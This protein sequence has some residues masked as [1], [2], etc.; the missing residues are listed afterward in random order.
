MRIAFFGTPDPAA[1]LLEAVVGSGFEVGPVVTAEDKPK[2]RGLHL[3]PSPVKRLALEMGLRVLTPKTLKD[4]NFLKA[5]GEF[6]AE[7]ALVCAYGHLIPKALLSSLP[8]GF[9]NVHY[10]LLPRYRGASCVPFTILF[11]ERV[12]GVSFIVLDEGLD[13]GPILAQFPLAIEKEDTAGSLTQKLTELAKAQ[14]VP[15]LMGYME[16]NIKAVPQRGEA[17]Y[18][19]L[20][21]KEDALIDFSLEPEVLVALTKAMNPWPKAYCFFRGERILIHRA[22]AQPIN[23]PQAHYLPK[24]TAIR[25]GQTFGILVKGGLFVPEVLQREGRQV[26]SN[27]A[28]LMGL[29][30]ILQTPFTGRSP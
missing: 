11:G 22:S 17:T 9:V 1:R 4:S 7:A 23:D 27:A 18:C 30:E 24:G 29:P 5:F 8:K 14:L 13:T 25:M 3:E 28:F 19:P 12:T 16:G 21:K 6:Q 10:S 26:I 2:G 15:V 20:L